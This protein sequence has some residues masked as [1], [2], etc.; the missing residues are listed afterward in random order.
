MYKTNIDCSFIRG[1]IE[2]YCTLVKFNLGL[3]F[4]SALRAS[5]NRRLNFTSGT[6]IFY[7]SP[8]EQSIFV[9][10]F[11]PFVCVCGSC[12]ASPICQEGQSERIF[13]IFAFSSR[14]FLFF[15]DFSLFS[16]IFGKYFAVRGGTL[17]P[18]PP[19]WLHHCSIVCVRGWWCVCVFTVLVV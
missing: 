15:P 14:L 5:V 16:P 17:L 11:A 2:N 4:T 12:V 8:Q 3:L 13:P 9:Y 10:Y 18:L 19:Q 7:K 1:I 6:I